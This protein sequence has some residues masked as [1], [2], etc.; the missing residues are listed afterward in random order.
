M[1]RTSGHVAHCAPGAIILT[2][3]ATALLAEHLRTRREPDNPATRLVIADIQRLSHPGP[4]S[5]DGLT[6]AVLAARQSNL[7]T[8]EAASLLG[9]SPAGVRKRIHRGQLAATYD[10]TRW[11]IPKHEIERTTDA[12][13]R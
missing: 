8:T 9:I 4:A 2:R 6:L 11:R 3:Q 12:P 7:T 1:R 5:R 10:G 13:I